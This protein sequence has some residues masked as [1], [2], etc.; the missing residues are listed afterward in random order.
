MNTP[1]LCEIN[2]TSSMDPNLKTRHY[3]LKLMNDFMNVKYHN[4]R[5]KQSEI[6]SQL[7]MSPSTI[8]RHRNDINMFSPYRINPNNVKKRSKM[9]KIDDNGDLK[10]HQMTSND[11]KTFSNDN[12][13]KTKTKINL[14]GGSVQDN[15]EINEH[16]LDKILKNNDY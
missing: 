1:S 5:L 8:Q 15:I 7:N 12:N 6:A 16:Y 3:K 10:R 2:K 11:L 4:P 9:A 14:K 13:K